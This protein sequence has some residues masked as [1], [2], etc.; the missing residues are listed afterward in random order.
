MRWHDLYRGLFR[1][2]KTFKA[3]RVGHRNTER[4]IERERERLGKRETFRSFCLT[5]NRHEQSLYMQHEI[6]EG[7]GVYHAWI[8]GATDE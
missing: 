1:Q 7:V 2:D 5:Y 4:L 6:E 3:H 8:D